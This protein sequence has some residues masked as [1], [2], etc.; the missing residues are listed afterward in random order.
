MSFYVLRAH[1]YVELRLELGWHPWWLVQNA[2]HTTDI[3]FAVS[4]AHMLCVKTSTGPAVFSYSSTRHMRKLQTLF[5]SWLQ[6][7]KSCG[8]SGEL[9]C[10]LETTRNWLT[11]RPNKE[12]PLITILIGGRIAVKKNDQHLKQIITSTEGGMH[13]EIS[14]PNRAQIIVC[15][16]SA[17]TSKHLRSRALVVARTVIYRILLVNFNKF[18]RKALLLRVLNMSRLKPFSTS[19]SFL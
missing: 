9:K 15:D 19:G 2:A 10:F 13:G 17:K 4:E 3:S 14:C 1:L 5:T 8:W 6:F 12:M 18:K 16:A 7:S 11:R